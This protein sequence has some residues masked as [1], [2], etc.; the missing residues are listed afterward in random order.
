M[1]ASKSP[2]TPGEEGPVRVTENEFAGDETTTDVKQ[3]FTL[4]E[5]LHGFPFFQVFLVMIARVSEPIAFTSLFPY[6]FFMVRHLRPDDSE[7]LVARYSGY[8]AGSFAL[9]QAFTGVFWGNLSDK[10][11][12]KPVL[13]LGL[14]GLTL[15]MFCFGMA[16]SFWTALLAR[17]LGGLLNGNTGV[18]R[19]VL[20]E[21][22]TE[23]KHQALAFSSMPLLWQVGCVVGPMIGGSL[24]MPID[25]HPGWFSP[26][27]PLEKTFF[28]HPFLLP[29]LVV[30]ILLL[31][32]CLSVILFLE[33]THHKLAEKR[34]R[35]DP[36]LKI[37]D[38]ILRV[39][40]RGKLV[41]GRE[42]QTSVEVTEETG[43]LSDAST[44]KSYGEDDSSSRSSN[45]SSSKKPKVLT[46]QVMLSIFAFA[47]FALEATAIDELLPVL[48]SSSVHKDQRFPFRLSGGL[49]MKSAE[50]GS[51]ISITGFVGIFFM[52]VFFPAIDGKYGSLVPWKIVS[53]CVPLFCFLI[54]YIVFLHKFD[55][56]TIAYFGA[57]A[58]YFFKAIVISTG[59]PAIQLMVQRSVVDRRTLGTVNGTSEMVAAVGRALGPIVWGFFMAFG[60]GHSIAV[61]PWWLLSLV[62]VA[63]GVLAFNL[64]EG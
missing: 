56:S 37:G 2:T 42:K 60:Q 6:V 25:T 29:N 21:I 62:G 31:L 44:I 32:S 49:G 15:S 28:K 7:A 9:C 64:T 23:R 46:R 20:G 54:P 34:N 19:T 18:L 10:Y 48:L 12:R 16:Q 17:S 52:L 38:K 33:E 26:G 36:G 45:S 5:Q 40:S 50:V 53:V 27:S 11:G 59:F 22:A 47:I 30:C 39:A 4:R 51:L 43:L 8:I 24:A 41:R 55:S 14:A 3:K 58:I 13:I 63:G 61:L 57:L 1:S 35:L